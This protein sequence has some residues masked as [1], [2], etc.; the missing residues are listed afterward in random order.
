MTVT[1]P[2]PLAA[3]T[4]ATVLG[5]SPMA[6]AQEGGAYIGAAILYSTQDAH[7]QGSSPSLPTTGAGGSAFGGSVEAGGFLL[8]RLALGVEVSLPRRFS[9]VQTTDY[10]R[11]FQQESRHRDVAVS[12]VLR[13]TTSRARP[14]RLAL[15]GGGGM[16]REDTRQRRRDQAG[17]LPTYPP[18]YGPW[19]D[20]YTFTR[21]TPAVVVGADLEVAIGRQV[22]LVGQMRSHLVRRSTDPSEPGWALG[23]GR[24]VWRPAV[25]LRASF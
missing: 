25:G 7:R 20:E 24:V 19:S 11:S 14:V 5:L 1:A 16:V 21:R 22:A 23:L 9:A 2:R 12:G 4:V 17:P 3:L 8:P 18:V 15:V 6:A 10:I 13:L